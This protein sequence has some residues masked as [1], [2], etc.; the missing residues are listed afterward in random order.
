MSEFTTSYET[1]WW[2]APC[3]LESD[4]QW[5]MAEQIFSKPCAL[6]RDQVAAIMCAEAV[7]WR[8]H[9]RLVGDALIVLGVRVMDI[10]ELNNVREHTLTAFAVIEGMKITYPR[11]STIPEES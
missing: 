11:S 4:D 3:L 1:S 7:S 8:C 6:S 2:L 10:F 5:R 9:R